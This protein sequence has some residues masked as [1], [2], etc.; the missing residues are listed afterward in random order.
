MKL[1]SLLV[2]AC[3]VVPAAGLWAQPPGAGMG[4]GGRGGPGAGG[5]MMNSP[6]MGMRGDSA[7]AAWDGSVYLVEGGILKKLSADLTEIKS[8]ELPQTLPPRQR[9]RQAGMRPAG[10]GGP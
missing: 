3:L 7:L 2:L 8:V 10:D 6:L 9:M 5:M 1:K 4:P